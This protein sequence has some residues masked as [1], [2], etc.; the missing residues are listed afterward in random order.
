MVD[1]RSANL[2]LNTRWIDPVFWRRCGAI[3]GLLLGLVGSTRSA[4]AWDNW[5]G[6]WRQGRPS[7]KVDVVDPP[8]FRLI[9]PFRTQK[10]GGPWQ[11]SNCGPAILGMV[12]DGFDIAGQAT[13][14]LRFRAHTYQG[15]VG[16]RTG[17][18]LEHVVHVAEDFGLPTYGLYDSNGR[19]R[20]WSIDDI[21][22][23]L[24]LGRPVMALVRLYLLPGY[25]GIGTR[26]GHYILL[27][28][29][30][31]DGFFYSDPL[32]TDPAAGRGGHI[33]SDQLSA[34]MGNSL[35]PGQA[36]AFGGTDGPRL[37]IWVP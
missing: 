16:M 4:Q 35:I 3:L 25:E 24:H 32:K 2:P 37:P 29:P 20:S 5:P 13:D 15:T 27:T 17:T 7:L 21:R 28:G 10:D 36:V 30:T 9:I 34:A 18:A 14:D 19:F 23:Q 22:A 8:V 11:S 33:S 31:E 12:L 1:G 6:E 26:W